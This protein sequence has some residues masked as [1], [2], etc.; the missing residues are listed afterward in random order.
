MVKEDRHFLDA[1]ARVSAIKGGDTDLSSMTFKIAPMNIE[2]CGVVYK[3]NVRAEK[4][5]TPSR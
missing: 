1:K 4:Y 5:S 3:D 2:R